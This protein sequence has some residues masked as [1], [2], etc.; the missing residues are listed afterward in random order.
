MAIIT[1]PAHEVNSCKNYDC[2]LEKIQ[3]Y[4]LAFISARVFNESD[5]KDVLQETFLKLHQQRDKYNP[6]KSF[7]NWALTIAKFQIMGYQTKYNRN[8]VLLCNEITD[9]ASSEE[10]KD[11]KT[12]EMQ[13]KALIHCIQNMPPHMKTIAF[14]R[15]RRSLQL[16]QISKIVS[17]P[18]GSVSAT[19]NRIRDHIHRSIHERYNM[20]EAENEKLPSNY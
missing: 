11:F 8:K 7:Y 3:P 20:I 19:L 17:R 2:K 10:P 18:V 14:L 16:K 5:S 13:R 9:T 4:L 6:N 1:T 15:F 12:E